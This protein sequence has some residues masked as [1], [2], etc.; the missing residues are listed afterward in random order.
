[1]KHLRRDWQGI[2]DLRGWVEPEPKGSILMRL[3]DLEGHFDGAETHAEAAE[4]VYEELQSLILDLLV[5]SGCD[6]DKPEAPSGSSIEPDEPVFMV[7]AKTKAARGT[8]IRYAQLAA[9]HG[10]DPDYCQRIKGW[11]DE[12]AA[13][14]ETKLASGEWVEHPPDAPELLP[15][16]DD[17]RPAEFEGLRG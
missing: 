16:P 6:S 1:M 5:L 2:Q 8:V 3:L 14:R 4:Q 9:M 13:Y 12:M 10:A 15:W 17:K 11:A 7:R